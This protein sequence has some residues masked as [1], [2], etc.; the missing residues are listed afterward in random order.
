MNAAAFLLALRRRTRTTSPAPDPLKDARQ[1]LAAH[2]DTAEGEAFR[3]VL[4]TIQTGQGEFHEADIWLFS[5][6]TL[7][8]VSALIEAR[9]EG[10]LW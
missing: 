2:G 10:R 7:P 9:L 6:D 5:N 4:E 3:R 1:F 8:L